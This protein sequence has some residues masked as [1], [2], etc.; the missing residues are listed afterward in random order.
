VGAGKVTDTQRGFGQRGGKYDP[1]ALLPTLYNVSY[2]G[3]KLIYQQL[4][5]L[6]VRITEGLMEVFHL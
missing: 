1:L 3:I 5:G 6:K 2:L 4:Q